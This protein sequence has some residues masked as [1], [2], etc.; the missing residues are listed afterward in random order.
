MACNQNCFAHWVQKTREP[1]THVAQWVDEDAQLE[2]DEDIPNG[3]V[4]P[5]ASLPHAATDSIASARI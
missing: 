5:H 2:I 1:D 3:T 4:F